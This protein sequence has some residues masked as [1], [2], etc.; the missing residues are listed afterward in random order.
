MIRAERNLES[1]REQLRADAQWLE[2]GEINVI[3]E[4][5]EHPTRDLIQPRM[6]GGFSIIQESSVIFAFPQ[7][8]LA[9]DKNALRK[10]R[11]RIQDKLTNKDAAFPMEG[12]D[13]NPYVGFRRR[14]R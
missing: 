2:F 1:A 11:T 5:T 13:T 6:P 8:P 10:L 4:H 7:Q 14:G 9:R 12:S 3:G